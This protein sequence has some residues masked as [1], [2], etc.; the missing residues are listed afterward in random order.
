V[1][2]ILHLSAYD[3]END[4]DAEEMESRE[5]EILAALGIADPYL[6][7]YEKC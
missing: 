3:H 4:R 6:A 7:E 1:H 5:R 2:G